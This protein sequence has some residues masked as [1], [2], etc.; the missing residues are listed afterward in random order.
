MRPTKGLHVRQHN[1]AI[2]RPRIRDK[3]ESCPWK[4]SREVLAKLLYIMKCNKVLRM[5]LGLNQN[6]FT[7]AIEIA[8]DHFFHSRKLPLYKWEMDD[9][10]NQSPST[11]KV[12]C[13]LGGLSVTQ[14]SAT[15][16]RSVSF[17]ATFSTVGHSSP[18]RQNSLTIYKNT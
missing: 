1:L 8:I 16:R 12:P 3:M 14:V 15:H 11:N 2:V 10:Q 13:P 6:S 5:R 18:S 7:P 9:G 4:A 17:P